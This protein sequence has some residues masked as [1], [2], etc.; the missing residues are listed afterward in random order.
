MSLKRGSK[1]G[2]LAIAFAMAYA[3]APEKSKVVHADD[4]DVTL[5]GCVIQ[6]NDGD[7]GYLLT[8]VLPASIDMSTRAA[9]RENQGTEGAAGTSGTPGSSGVIYW[10]DDLENDD[11]IPNYAGKRVEIRGELEGDIKRGE[12]EVERDGDW[13]KIKIKSDGKDVKTRIPWVSVMPNNTEAVGTSGG[14]LKDGKE[15]E[16][17]I[18]VRKLD[19][20]DVKIVSGTCS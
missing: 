9:A 20:K 19:V 12:M 7:K 16:I 1:L 4:D 10:L 17:N 6:G 11:D 14:T 13:V 3:M 18:N 8:Q 15:I 5:T 2:L